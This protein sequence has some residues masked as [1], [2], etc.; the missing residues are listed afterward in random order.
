MNPTDNAESMSERV[1]RLMREDIIMGELAPGQSFNES[2]LVE[3]FQVSTSPLREALSRLR[4]DGLIKVLPRKGYVVTELTLNDFHDLIQMRL[5]L[6]SSAAELA[7][8]R[9]TSEQIATLTQLST[10]AIVADDPDSRRHFM[11]ANQEFHLMIAEISGNRRLHAAL[12]QNFQD[13]QRVLFANVGS[14]DGQTSESDH[15]PIIDALARRDSEKARLAAIVHVK[16]SRDRII[17]RMLR[18]TEELTLP[19]LEL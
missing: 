3:R 12:E 13:I 10:V 4:Q 18:R 17:D 6:E 1:Y 15:A 9:T 19:P 7:A 5:I 11:Q 8:P 2:T 14:S 16:Q